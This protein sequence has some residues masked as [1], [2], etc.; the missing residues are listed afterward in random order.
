M[1]ID[2]HVFFPEKLEKASIFKI[3]QV[4]TMDVFVTDMFVERVQS[5]KLKGF[6]F[7]LLW[8]SE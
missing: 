4:P 3:P 1:D 6:L 8:S 2:V 5:A 7:P